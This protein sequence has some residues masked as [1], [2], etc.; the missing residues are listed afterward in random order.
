MCPIQLKQVSFKEIL[1]I[2]YSSTMCKVNK[3]FIAEA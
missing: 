3:T 1:L 2:M